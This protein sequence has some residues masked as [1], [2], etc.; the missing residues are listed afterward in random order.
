MTKCFNYGYRFL[1][2]SSHSS[3]STFSINCCAYFSLIMTLFSHWCSQLCMLI[4]NINANRIFCIPHRHNRMLDE[5]YFLYEFINISHV[6]HT[7]T[8][9]INSLWLTVMNLDVDL[10]WWMQKFLIHIKTDKNA[11]FDLFLMDICIRK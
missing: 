8:Y 2:P 4:I 10:T 9:V 5:N 1:C 6:I 7:N 11:S 3:S